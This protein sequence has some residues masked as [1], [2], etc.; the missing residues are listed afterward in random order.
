MAGFCR[1]R[2]QTTLHCIGEGR[3]TGRERRPHNAWEKVAGM[4]GSSDE[5][6]QKE[7]LPES[8]GTLVKCR[9]TLH[10]F[11]RYLFLVSLRK[12]R[13][14]SGKVIRSLSLGP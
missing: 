12:L 6:C 11:P 3:V 10:S 2:K 9:F 8:S 7:V 14:D 4:D 13:E 5:W 1:G